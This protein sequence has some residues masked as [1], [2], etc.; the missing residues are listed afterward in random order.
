M[1]AMRRRRLW[2]IVALATLVILAVGL[3]WGADQPRVANSFGYALAGRDG[4]PTYVFAY[5]RRYHSD[6]V[7]AGAGWCPEHGAPRCYTQTDLPSHG[8]WPLESIGTM[9]TLF[10]SPRTLL[11]PV[12]VPTGP[13]GLTA[14]IVIADGPNCYVMYSLE[15]GP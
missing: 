13:T 1:E 3:F 12:G 9:F 2:G 7:C 10:G 15:G 14:P 6:Q 5:G 8:A 11:R 4:L